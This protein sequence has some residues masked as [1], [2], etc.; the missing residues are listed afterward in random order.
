VKQLK[1]F[2]RHRWEISL[3]KTATEPVIW[4]ID[5]Q[6]WPR[7]YL[8]VELIERG[9]DAI[10]FIELFEVIT[11]LNDPN[12][13][14]PR[15][16]VLEIYDLSFKRDEL[17]TLARTGI[18]MIVLGGSVELNE[19]LVRNFRWVAAMRRPFTIGKVADVVEELFGRKI[20]RVDSR[21]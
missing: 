21:E 18:P 15:L 20:Q 11:A 10:G 3:D 4:I 5:R 16:I 12:Y 6:Q 2:S 1:Y 8:R 17:D 7:A 14:K 13:P 19:E 9:F